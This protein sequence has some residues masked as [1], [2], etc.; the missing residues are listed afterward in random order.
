MGNSLIL[1]CSC[2]MELIIL[3]MLQYR[4]KWIPLPFANTKCWNENHPH[5]LKTSLER[6]MRSLRCWFL[7]IIKLYC[8]KTMTPLCFVIEWNYWIHLQKNFWKSSSP[9]LIFF[10]KKIFLSL[11]LRSKPEKLYSSQRQ[12][13]LW[14]P[15]HD[16]KI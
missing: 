12:E 15:H 7:A 2:H 10:S 8:M 9:C 1:M 3:K 6:K 16:G 5:V 13:S 14:S 11:F 4:R